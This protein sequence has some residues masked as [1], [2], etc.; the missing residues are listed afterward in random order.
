MQG[1]LGLLCMSL[2]RVVKSSLLSK[3]I[4]GKPGKEK[5]VNCT[6]ESKE[7]TNHSPGLSLT[8]CPML[9]CELGTGTYSEGPAHIFK[10]VSELGGWTLALSSPS[11]ARAQ[12]Q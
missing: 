6:I 3:L 5:L 9:N 7:S 2:G 10:V 1:Q 4:R 12:H 8:L 11:T